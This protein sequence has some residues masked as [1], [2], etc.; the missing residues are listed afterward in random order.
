MMGAILGS[1]MHCRKKEKAQE[2]KEPE[3]CT[4]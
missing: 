2:A 3:C 4:P 1:N